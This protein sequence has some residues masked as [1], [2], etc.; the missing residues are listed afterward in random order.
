LDCDRLF[1]ID[2]LIITGFILYPILSQLITTLSRLAF[3][4]CIH[5]RQVFRMD[6]IPLKLTVEVKILRGMT[7]DLFDV[8]TDIGE[9]RAIFSRY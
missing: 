7:Q 5:L 2:P 4:E 6:V 1:V 3:E 8:L 9:L